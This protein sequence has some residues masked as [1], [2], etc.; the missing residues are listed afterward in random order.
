MGC[1]ALTLNRMNEITSILDQINILAKNT[2]PMCGKIINK[3]K[4]L[5]KRV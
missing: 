5:Q 2:N 4:I 1:G 3:L